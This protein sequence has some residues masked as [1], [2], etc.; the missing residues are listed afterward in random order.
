MS[1]EEIINI[2]DDSAVSLTLSTLSCFFVILNA[3]INIVCLSYK[4][5]LLTKIQTKMLMNP[6]R[7][8]L[9]FIYHFGLI[10]FGLFA[11]HSW[12]FLPSDASCHVETDW[13]MVWVCNGVISVVN[14]MIGCFKPH[15]VLIMIYINIISSTYVIYYYMFMVLAQNN[16]C[17]T[18]F[19][20]IPVMLLGVINLYMVPELLTLHIPKAPESVN[21][22]DDSLNRIGILNFEKDD[23]KDV[24]FRFSLD[25]TFITP[26][27]KNYV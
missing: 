22:L 19:I 18:M 11:I 6:T 25:R 23:R 13:F 24:G 7:K 17:G 26:N 9:L 2:K 3:T 20:A 8:F 12:R 4:F 5:P 14:N 16:L 21:V 27:Q 10:L 15:Y 1:S